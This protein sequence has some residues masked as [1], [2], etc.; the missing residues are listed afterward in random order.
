MT[1]YKHFAV[2]CSMTAQSYPSVAT[3]TVR[4]DGSF[5]IGSVTGLRFPDRFP[6]AEASFGLNTQFTRNG[7]GVF[8]N[9]LQS[10]DHYETTLRMICCRSRAHALIEYLTGTIRT[11]SVS[12]DVEAGTY[13]FGASNGSNGT[14][15]CQWIDSEVTVMHSNF[16]RYEFDLNFSLVSVA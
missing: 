9:T 1:P 8:L 2:N 11:G 7:T 15:T 6:Q 10:S 3:P 13:L 5:S 12:L 16:S 14:Y 4:N